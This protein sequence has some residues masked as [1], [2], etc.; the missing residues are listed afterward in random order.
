M[1]SYTLYNYHIVLIDCV[2]L[3]FLL[4]RKEEPST[5][6]HVSSELR[7]KN[8]DGGGPV[9]AIHALAGS[10][11][12]WLS[13]TLKIETFL[14]KTRRNREAAGVNRPIRIPCRGSTDATV[15]A[16]LPGMPHQLKWQIRRSFT[17]SDGNSIDVILKLANGLVL[18]V[19]M[20]VS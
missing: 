16:C 6:M 3:D 11:L 2:C 7:R 15:L 17:V 1:I 9:Q 4:S 20:A 14:A 5:W 12:T 13:A 18:S 19:R 8:Q 10:A